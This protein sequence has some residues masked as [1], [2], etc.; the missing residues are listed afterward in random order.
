V[1]EKTATI[2]TTA[3]VLH[4]PGTIS[5][6]RLTLEKRTLG[7]LL[8]GQV[9]VTVRACGVCRTDLNIVEGDLPPRHPA[10]VP[11]HQIVGIVAAAAADVALAVGTRVGISWL[12]GTDGTCP[13][14]LEGRENLFFA[15]IRSSRGTTSMEAMPRPS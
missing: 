12:G 9:L 7:P 13:F 5:K 6:D 4:E 14:C 1:E 3:A 11:G 2:A 15:T 10:I 8:S